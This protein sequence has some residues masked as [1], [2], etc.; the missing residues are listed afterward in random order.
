M[1]GMGTGVGPPK[2]AWEPAA[3]GTLGDVP[4]LP[5]LRVHRR[6]MDATLVIQGRQK[7]LNTTSCSLELES[8]GQGSHG[9][10]ERRRS[11]SGS[12]RIFRLF[13]EGIYNHKPVGNL[14]MGE[15][16]GPRGMGSI[17]LM[18]LKNSHRS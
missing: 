13:P 10:S 3:W 7:R 1:R 5:Q 6:D 18:I 8:T 12:D 9:E 11:A 17:C 4:E 16:G 2:E 14:W 15:K